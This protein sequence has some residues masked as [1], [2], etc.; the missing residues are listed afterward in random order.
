[1]IMGNWL[2]RH[3]LSSM[4]VNHI[5]SQL[6]LLIIPPAESVGANGFPAG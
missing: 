6:E 4:E 2:Y 5:N 1:M 3:V